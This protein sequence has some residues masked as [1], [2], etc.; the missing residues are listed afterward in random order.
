[1]GERVSYGEKYGLTLDFRSLDIAFT[2]ED[3]GHQAPVVN[4]CSP[5]RP[6]TRKTCY[7]CLTGGRSR[8]VSYETPFQASPQDPAPYYPVPLADNLEKF[9]RLKH[10]IERD[11]P[12]LLLSGRLGTYKY[13]DMFQAVG[14]AL[15]LAKNRLGELP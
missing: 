13:L 15:A 3:W 1:P 2:L 9:R 7:A 8:V 6:H 12:H 14:Q 4:F 5:R 11:H 10:L